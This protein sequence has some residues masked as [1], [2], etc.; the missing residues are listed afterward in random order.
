M[1]RWNFIYKKKLFKTP[2][3]STKAQLLA[4]ENV[5]FASKFVEKTENSLRRQ[6][7]KIFG[8]YAIVIKSSIRHDFGRFW[9]CTFLLNFVLFINQ[10]EEFSFIS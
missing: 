1:K 10:S 8:M 5:R 2:S 9:Q 3:I 4:Y 6:E 7:A